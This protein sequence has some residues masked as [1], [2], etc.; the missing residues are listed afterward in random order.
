M[1]CDGACLHAADLA[2]RRLG[3]NQGHSPF[4]FPRAFSPLLLRCI[5]SPL[6]FRRYFLSNAC[7]QL[8]LHLPS[9]RRAAPPP[10]SS[11]ATSIPSARAFSPARQFRPPE[12][13]APVGRTHS[14]DGKLQS[15]KISSAGRDV[16]SHRPLP[17]L[18]FRRCALRPSATPPLTI[19]QA[20]SFEA[21]SRSRPRAGTAQY[22]NLP[23]PRIFDECLQ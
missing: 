18:A 20:Q 10:V 21:D 17:H 14:A 13:E 4:T 3:H 8:A 5:F 1:G 22:R 23:A 7:R 6:S 9:I 16:F 11:S 19:V 15:A 2:S 12:I